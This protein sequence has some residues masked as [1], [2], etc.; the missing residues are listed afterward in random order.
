MQVALEEKSDIPGDVVPCYVQKEPAHKLVNL[1]KNSRWFTSSEGG[2]HREFDHCMAKWLNQA[3]VKTQF[4]RM[5][6]AGIHGNGHEM[7]LEKNSDEI[8]KFI[9]TWMQKNVRAE[10]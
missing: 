6:E 8:A 9:A 10:R 5:E 3:G 2:Y 1:G 4:V 7:M